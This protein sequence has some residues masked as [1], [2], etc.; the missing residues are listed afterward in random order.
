[1]S[2]FPIIFDLKYLTGDHFSPEFMERRRL[3]YIFVACGLVSVSFLTASTISLNGYPDIPPYNVALLSMRSSSQQNDPN[4]PDSDTFQ[5]V[6]MHQHLAHPPGPEPTPGL[7][8]NISDTLL[9]AFACIRKPDERFLNT[10]DPDML[11][12][13]E[14]MFDSVTLESPSAPYDANHTIQP[15]GP[16]FKQSMAGTEDERSP[17]NP[18]WEGYLIVTVKD[19]VKELAETKDAYVSYLVSAKDFVFLR[20]HL[21]KDFP[22][23]ALAALEVQ[24]IRP[25]A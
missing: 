22:A 24:D 5:H 19:P 12:D 8:D 14:D 16:G 23:C 3:E 2:G 15:S 9:N 21:V 17:H 13:E 25:S 1:M 4:A 7:I 6:H 18:K 11:G 20:D 10:S